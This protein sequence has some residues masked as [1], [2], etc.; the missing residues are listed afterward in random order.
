VSLFRNSS[1]LRAGVPAILF[2]LTLVGGCRSASSQPDVSDVAVNLDIRRFERDLA[3]LD[4]SNPSAGLPA[5]AQ[6]YPD[7]LNFYLDT[8]MG[9]GLRGNYTQASPG[10]GSGLRLFL[11]QRD[12]RGVFDSVAKHF[13][14]TGAFAADLRKGFQYY[15]HYF[16]QRPVPRVVT[17]I[18][19]LNSWNAITYGNLLGIGL[20]MYLGKDYPFYASVGVPTYASARFTPA[21]IVPDAFRTLY[22]DFN[23]FDTDGRTLLDMMIQRGKEQ[24]FL[25]K[26][27]P[28]AA[29]TLR[30]GYTGAQA[31]WCA[32]NETGIWNFFI[33]ENLLYET[34][35]QKVLR[36]VTDGPNTPQLP[37]E[38]PGNVGTFT[39]MRIV[40]A[41]M[42]AHPDA[43]LQTLLADRT[44]AQKFLEDSGYKPR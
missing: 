3:A 37:A 14:D 32:E 41:W 44:D 21:Y 19:G 6:R 22:R 8:L 43:T 5:L 36:Y 2:V 15:R 9:F 25:S 20:D 16:P 42:E 24:Y 35:L 12:Y 10:L 40:E 33:S 13:P 31:A 34:N 1:V 27:V 39:G 11:S 38:A 29:D 23:P 4:T 7:F 18:S 17:F 26:V 28:F 30:T